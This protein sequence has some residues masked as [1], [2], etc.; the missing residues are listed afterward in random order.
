MGNQEAQN[1]SSFMESANWGEETGKMLA[2]S[3]SHLNEQAQMQNVAIFVDYDNVY[4]TLMKEYRHDPDHQDF[5]KNLIDQLWQYYGLQNIRVFNLYGD[6]DK[7]NASMTSLQK[8]RVTIRNVY[9]NGKDGEFRKNASDIELSIEAMEL[10][11]TDNKITTFVFV[12]A[13]SDMIPIM[14]KI[15]FKGKRVELF[16]IASALAKHVE[17]ERYCANF[18]N[19]IEFLNVPVVQVNPFDYIDRAIVLIHE[20]LINPR[21]SKRFLGPNLLKKIMGN[22]LKLPEQICSKLINILEENEYITLQPF[23]LSD[24]NPGRKA[25]L[26]ENNP[27]VK[28]IIARNLTEQAAE[29]A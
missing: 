5:E 21:N 22:D 24:G 6:F 26:Q 18:V 20:W 4:W 27:Y 11:I 9:S 15:M 23:Y 29:E 14:S 7:M 2:A 25:V 13:D 12:S 28:E 16:Y 17:L 8:K 10:A 1:I 19:L 3:F